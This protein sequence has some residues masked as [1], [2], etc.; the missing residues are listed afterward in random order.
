[1]RYAAGVTAQDG[2]TDARY[3]PAIAYIG[4]VTGNAQYTRAATALASRLP[5]G[6][7]GKPFTIAGRLGFSILSQQP[8]SSRR[9]ETVR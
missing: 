4:R 3:F 1:V 5:F 2:K 8:P 9:V 6:N 7:W